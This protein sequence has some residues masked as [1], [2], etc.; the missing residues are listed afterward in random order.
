MRVIKVNHI[1]KRF[2][3][4]L[5]L[6]NPR[7]KQSRQEKNADLINIPSITKKKKGARLKKSSIITLSLVLRSDRCQLDWPS[8]DCDSKPSNSCHRSINSRALDWSLLTRLQ[9]ADLVS[10]GGVI[11]LRAR[12][13]G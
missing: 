12:F 3:K 1:L 6:V 5:I 9:A 8:T 4:N 13:A 2:T 7:V 11:G 10:C